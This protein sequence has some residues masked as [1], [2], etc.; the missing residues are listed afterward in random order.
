MYSASGILFIQAWGCLFVTNVWVSEAVWSINMLYES[1]IK[2]TLPD[3]AN[4]RSTRQFCISNHPCCHS[5]TL[6]TL[7]SCSLQFDYR[8]MFTLRKFC[9]LCD[10]DIRFRLGLWSDALSTRSMSELY[11]VLMFVWVVNAFVL[12]ISMYKWISWLYTWMQI[13]MHARKNVCFSLLFLSKQKTICFFNNRIPQRVEI[14]KLIIL[15][16]ILIYEIFSKKNCTRSIRSLSPGAWPPP[17][18]STLSSPTALIRRPC[19]RL[20][21]TLVI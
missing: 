11:C 9:C 3:S 13:C 4:L 16:L 1:R 18:P 2:R 19:R 10:Y 14:N 21:S 12:H 20:Q 17:S 8:R 15:T 5:L 6:V 7:L